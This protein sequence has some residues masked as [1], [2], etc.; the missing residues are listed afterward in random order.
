MIRWAG[1]PR[2]ATG[3]ELL[4]A[5]EALALSRYLSK[6]G[7]DDRVSL[8][9]RP[10]PVTVHQQ[11]DMLRA[12]SRVA[13]DPLLAVRM[14]L[15]LH[16]TSYGIAGLA[17]LSSASLRSALQ[18]LVD[19]GALLCLKVRVD[20]E[21]TGG[22]ARLVLNNRFELAAGLLQ[23]CSQLEVAKLCTLLRDLSGC[24]VTRVGLPTEPDLGPQMEMLLG[25]P[26]QGA[27]G[28]GF[29]TF[30]A[31]LLD[32][33]L[34]QAD[35]ATHQS[36]LRS[37]D[38]LIAAL[39]RCDETRQRV[40]RMVLSAKGA[41]PTLSEIA[42]R[43]FL[44]TRTLRR[45]LEDA[46]TSYQ[47]IVGETRWALAVGYLTRTTLSTGE[48]AEVLG[49]SDTANFRHAFKRWTGESP[50]QYRRLARTAESAGPASEAH[51]ARREVNEGPVSSRG[52][53]AS[54]SGHA[55]WGLSTC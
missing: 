28:A 35:E 22:E 42:G 11:L 5:S 54:L 2:F 55:L 18:I 15:A 30:D 8:L 46:Q 23:I 20:L 33:R 9:Q 51:L 38:E 6:Q 25:A 53:A 16:P 43:L 52:A 39:R 40:R 36:S 21:L 4:A 19:Y 49:Y 3:D 50:Q 14:G 41:I 45:R 34:P 29:I 48:I 44:S 32:A 31:A 13:C 1:V 17:L 27:S 7:L 10:G 24:R 12:A 26:V 37:C 47:E